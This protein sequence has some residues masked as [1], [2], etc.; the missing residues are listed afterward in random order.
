MGLVGDVGEERLAVEGEAERLATRVGVADLV[1]AGGR[2]IEYDPIILCC[3][4]GHKKTM[5]FVES[6]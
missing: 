5:L 3:D 1:A 6:Y 2:L 4:P